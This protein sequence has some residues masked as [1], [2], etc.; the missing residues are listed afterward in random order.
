M[1][2][3]ERTMYTTATTLGKQAT[4]FL[5]RLENLFELDYSSYYISLGS[6]PVDPNNI[7]DMIK[8]KSHRHLVL[9]LLQAVNFYD[10]DFS[11]E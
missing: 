5:D 6:N 1:F 11:F 10:E 4:R 8:S 9:A 7:F 3:K 2:R